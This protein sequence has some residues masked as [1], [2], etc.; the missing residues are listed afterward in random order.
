[1]ALAIGFKPERNSVHMKIFTS[2]CDQFFVREVSAEATQSQQETITFSVSMAFDPKPWPEESLQMYVS[3]DQYDKRFT[4]AGNIFAYDDNVDVY[5]LIA[6]ID[7]EFAR[8]WT[9]HLRNE[10][11]T[12]DFKQF[13]ADQF[14]FYHA[15]VSYFPLPDRK[16]SLTLFASNKVLADSYSRPPRIYSLANGPLFQE[17]SFW[18]FEAAFRF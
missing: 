18:G 4:N 8:Y 15:G 10:I 11:G 13:E 14:Y 5:S 2:M 7:F 1:M 12:F 6:D 3:Y 9:I 16:E 17:I